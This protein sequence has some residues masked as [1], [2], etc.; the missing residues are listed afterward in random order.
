MEKEIFLGIWVATLFTQWIK[1]YDHWTK[2]SY[3]RKHMVTK[4]PKTLRIIHSLPLI[5]SRLKIMFSIWYFF[6]RLNSHLPDFKIVYPQ[7]DGDRC[8][9]RAW[10]AE[11]I[12]LIAWPVLQYFKSRSLTVRKTSLGRIIKK[13]FTGDPCDRPARLLGLLVYMKIY[14]TFQFQLQ[15]NF[16]TLMLKYF[17]LFHLGVFSR[18]VCRTRRIP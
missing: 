13:N 15:G 7:D 6:S 5:L 11:G 18:C 4:T 10:S 17:I 8:W 16:Q 3:S 9:L 14:R 12:T 2:Q 1:F